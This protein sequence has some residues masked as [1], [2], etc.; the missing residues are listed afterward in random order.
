MSG[1]VRL[2]IIGVVLFFVLLTLGRFGS[3]YVDWLWFQSVGAQDVFA[4]RFLVQTSIFVVAG[5][6]FFVV[7]MQNAAIAIRL[8][9]RDA[10]PAVVRRMPQ[11]D[12]S[13][14]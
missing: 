7:F 3:I 6:A 5:L 9:S 13:T 14:D 2:V 11:D 4:T 8:A 10:I 12:A 1:Q